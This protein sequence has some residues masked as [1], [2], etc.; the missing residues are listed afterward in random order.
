VAEFDGSRVFRSIRID[1]SQRAPLYRQ[2][3]DGLWELILNGDLETGERPPTVR[4]YAGDLGVHPN[5]VARAYQEL[6]MLGVVE[7]RGGD[8]TVIS[9]RESEKERLERTLRLEQICQDAVFAARELG[10]S[11]NDVLDTLTELRRSN[12]TG[13]P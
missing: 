3:V 4:Q 7:R 9:I 12:R 13:S 11:I 6:E 2:I 5:T 10:F 1:A 8:G